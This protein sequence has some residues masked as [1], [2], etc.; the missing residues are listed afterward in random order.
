[1]LRKLGAVALA[2]TMLI[3]S[4][5]YALAQ[6]GQGALTPGKAASVKQAESFTDS[7]T[8]ILLLGV[9]VVA[10]GIALVASGDGHGVVGSTTTCPLTGCPTPPPPPPPTTTTTTTGT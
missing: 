6:G 3:S 1:M 7:N 5:T 8:L 10:G 2:T 4:A 9:G